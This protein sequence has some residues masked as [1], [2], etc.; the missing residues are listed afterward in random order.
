MRNERPIFNGGWVHTAT[1]VLMGWYLMVPP[2][3]KAGDIVVSEAPLTQKVDLQ[4]L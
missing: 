4:F 3:S 2:H 1:F